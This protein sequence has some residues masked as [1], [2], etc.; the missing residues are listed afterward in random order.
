MHIIISHAKPDGPYCAQALQTLALPR[1][2]AHL[3]YAG[4]VQVTRANA[5]AL[6]PPAERLYAQVLGLPVQ[7]GL[8]PWAAWQAQQRRLPLAT[9]TGWAQL[10]LCHWQINADH[11]A[12]QDPTGLQIT[13]AESDTL[14]EAMHEFFAEDG[15]TLHPGDA[16]SWLAC[17]ALFADLPTASLDRAC[18]D[19][20]D[21]W[22]PRHAQAKALR[23]LQN[24]MQML[25]YTHP[26]ND[27]RAAKRLPAINSFWVSASGKLPTGFTAKSA[28]VQY[29]TTLRAPALSDN[30]AA[31]TA[32]WQRIDSTVLAT[33]LASA[34][35]RI[36]LCGTAQAQTFEIGTQSLWAKIINRFTQPDIHAI[37]QSL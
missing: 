13:Q 8:V 29:L 14:M 20:V 36:S 16:G 21:T 4:A 35:T 6:T 34:P 12:M 37:L 23:R 15:I 1:L 32:E 18:G 24:E 9:D 25:L 26:V 22:L 19:K 27:A 7:D 11:V 31:W 3:Q 17:S 28:E 2:R 30:P 33:D 10:N 5:A